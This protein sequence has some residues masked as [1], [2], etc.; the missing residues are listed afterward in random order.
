MN[1]CQS[2]A[3]INNYSRSLV[4][5]GIPTVLGIQYKL[6]ESAAEIMSTH[7]YYDLLVRG[8][9]LPY[10]CSYARSKLR[11]ISHRRTNYRTTVEVH[12]YL[13]PV[14]FTSEPFEGMGSQIFDAEDPTISAAIDADEEF[15]GRESIIL[16]LANEFLV[17]LNR[18]YLHG[19]AGSGKSALTSHFSWWWKATGLVQDALRVDFATVRCE[20]WKDIVHILCEQIQDAE[21]TTEALL[22]K[23]LRTNRHLIIFDSLDALPTPSPNPFLV[24]LLNFVKAFKKAKSPETASFIM[25]IGRKALPRLRSMIGS[26]YELPGLDL[27]SSLRLS[28]NTLKRFSKDLEMTNMIAFGYMKEIVKLADGNPLA[29]QPIMADFAARKEG[30][31]EYYH[32]LTSWKQFR[33]DDVKSPELTQHR[34]LR[35]VFD[36][37]KSSWEFESFKTLPPQHLIYLSPFW[38]KIPAELSSYWKFLEI[39]FRKVV[40]RPIYSLIG[41]HNMKEAA[42]AMD[43]IEV[44]ILD[45]RDFSNHDFDPN[46]LEDLDNKLGLALAS[47]CRSRFLGL[48]T[49]LQLKQSPK[50]EYYWIHPLLT[51]GLRTM[52]KDDTASSENSVIVPPAYQR[53]YMRRKLISW[54]TYGTFDATSHVHFE[55]ENYVTADN[56][57]CSIKFPN[58][59]YRGHCNY[60]I[61]SCG[62]RDPKSIFIG[63]GLADRGI[64][65]ILEALPGMKTTWFLRSSQNLAL[66]GQRSMRKLTK[67]HQAPTDDIKDQSVSSFSI[68]GLV[69]LEF[70]LYGISTSFILSFGLDKYR[71]NLQ[72]LEQFGAT[73]SVGAI[74]FHKMLDYTKKFLQGFLIYNEA[75]ISE[76]NAA[77][78]ATV[79]F[80][81]HHSSKT[82]EAFR[83]LPEPSDEPDDYRQAKSIEKG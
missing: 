62:I 56:F 2:A 34:S 29:L 55:F 23:N 83:N 58:R 66:W 35:Q 52:R 49:P 78:H 7:L 11:E 37:C 41:L 63:H 69:Y 16:S 14:L 26:E 81:H 24:C 75:S 5:E 50:A 46:E 3:G 80:M 12:D 76:A 61:D 47:L 59:N 22:I 70:V 13:N 43:P 45:K 79:D 67:G 30:P 8:R 32:R 20:Q 72:E 57:N 10:A 6:L 64:E 36:L 31:P 15:L 27:S 42:N 65:I 1:A 25:F 39:E 68:H 28:F 73:E 19:P 51:I 48:S 54:P 38:H 74:E 44:Q 4:Q 17:N 9:S 53:F 40:K 60:I 18:Q 21:V 33:I 77:Y 71:E 82:K